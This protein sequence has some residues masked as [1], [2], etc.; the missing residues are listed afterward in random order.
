MHS[1]QIIEMLALDAM[2]LIL[3][4]SSFYAMWLLPWTRKESDQVQKDFL[5]YFRTPVI[6]VQAKNAK[7]LIPAGS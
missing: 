3:L 1:S 6:D 4:G 5:S 2:I 7:K